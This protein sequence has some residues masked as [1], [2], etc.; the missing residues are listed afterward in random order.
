VAAPSFQQKYRRQI[1]SNASAAG[2]QLDQQHDDRE[3]QDEMDQPTRNVKAEAEKP[4]DN[5]NDNESIKH[6]YVR[7]SSDS[8]LAPQLGGKL[9]GVLLALR[10]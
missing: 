9:C 3:H 2:E 6:K 4:K 1:C 8:S 7:F 10:P 5:K